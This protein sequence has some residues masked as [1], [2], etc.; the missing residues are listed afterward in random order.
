MW[1]PCS[2]LCVC[3]VHTALQHTSSFC[4]ISASNFSPSHPWECTSCAMFPWSKSAH[5]FLLFSYPPGGGSG[6]SLEPRIRPGLSHWWEVLKYLGHLLLHWDTLAVSW[7]FDQHSATGFWSYKWH[8][9]LLCHNA[10]PYLWVLYCHVILCCSLLSILF[11]FCFS[12]SFILNIPFLDSLILCS[13]RSCLLVNPCSEFF[14]FVLYFQL[15]N[16]PL[17]LF[18]SSCFFVDIIIWHT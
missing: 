11:T 17:I 2:L 6:R 15:H 10:G 3:S 1:C 12:A 8:L 13:A 4:R 18:H 14:N 16:Y 5:F 9:N 7:V